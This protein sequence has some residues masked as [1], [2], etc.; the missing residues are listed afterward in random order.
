MISIAG[1]ILISREGNLLLQRRDNNP[2]I[3]S[4]NMISIFGGSAE[5]QESNLQDVA[6]REIREETG[7]NL[8][9][10]AY[11]ALVEFEN[12]YPDGRIIRGKFFLLTEIDTSTLEITEGTLIEIPVSEVGKYIHEMVP[13]TCFVVSLYLQSIKKQ[14]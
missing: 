2:A 7:L 10:S 11:Q 6:M 3:S 8:K 13:T 5:P 1:A 14:S 9:A 12:Q 4:P